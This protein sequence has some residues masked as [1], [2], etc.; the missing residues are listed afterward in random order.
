MSAPPALLD[1]QALDLAIDRLTSRERALRE[2]EALTAARRE[3]DEAERI[4]GELGLERDVLDRD[5]GKLEHEIDSLSQKAD[6]EQRRMSDGSVANARELEAMGREV[7]NLRRRIAER[8]DELLVVMERREDVER[9]TGAAKTTA[10]ELRSRVQLVASDATVELEGVVRELDAKR[11]E[12]EGLAHGIDPE[13]LELYEE[14]RAHKRG[15]GAA[16]LVD[17]VCQG[18]HET[19]SSAELDRVKRAD[20]VARCEHCRRILVL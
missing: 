11:G 3:A 2:G 14:L 7:E 9:R 19:L 13:T 8:E 4:Q 18:C 1:L 10:D 16:A 15:V 20:G 5:G 17:G 6:A 12:R